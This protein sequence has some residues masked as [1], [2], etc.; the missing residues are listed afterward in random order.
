MVRFVG[1]ARYPWLLLPCGRSDIVDPTEVGHVGVDD[2][3][4][5][6]QWA[7]VP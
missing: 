1:T 7:D 3:R 5:F 6:Q 2:T 4:V